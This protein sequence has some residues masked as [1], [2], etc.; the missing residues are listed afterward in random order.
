[1]REILIAEALGSTMRVRT[2]TVAGTQVASFNAF[3]T[4]ASAPS[5]A[6][7]DTDGDGDDE[8]I[9]ARSIGGQ[10]QVRI[11]TSS[12]ILLHAFFA[13]TAT[14]RGGVYVAAGDTDGDGDAE[15]IVG[16]GRGA[17][18]RVRVFTVQG[19][20]IRSFSAYETTYR[21]GVT[22]GAGDLDGDGTIEIVTGPAGARVP[23]VRV[24]STLGVLQR[25]MQ[26]YA[27]TYRSGVQL[28][29]GDLTDDGKSEIV[30]G[31]AARN[32]A[33]VR[34]F[35]GTGKLLN[36]FF[37]EGKSLRN[38]VR[39]LAYRQYVAP[40]P[41]YTV[42]FFGDQGMTEDAKALLRLIKDQGADAIVHLGDFDYADN[43]T[44]WEAQ[45]TGILGTTFPYLG[46]VGN[47]DVPVWS[48]YQTVLANQLSRTPSMRCVGDVG[49][50]ATCT[51][52][53]VTVILSGVG[54]LGTEHETYLAQQVAAA[55]GPWV[56][57]AWHKNQRLMQVGGKSDEVGWEAYDSCRGQGAIVATGHEHSYSR[58]HLL[59]NFATQE[60]ASTASELRLAPGKTFAFVS[61]LGGYSVR[62]QNASLAANPWW[63]SVYTSTQNAS[64]GA[65][66][67]TFAKNG[68]QRKASCTFRDIAGNTPDSF[69]LVSER[70]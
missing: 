23:D 49:E 70:W 16:S 59:S 53:G 50:Q 9:V 60:I 28:S 48:G 38:G 44:Q 34:I 2:V 42:A 15:V 10:P 64:A 25:S 40:Y 5:L 29:V 65:L 46:L 7:G 26:A 57:C 68:V 18:P 6:A 37:T 62:S 41:N 8:I 43:P 20:L 69:T 24:F 47:H 67:C 30:V 51:F 13:T 39:V 55:R 52:G 22:V 14:F 63:A 66:F 31:T 21:Q 56:I 32:G 35:R 61:G 1:M 12:G 17:L 45:Y 4:G 27:A 11:Y 3:T 54:T 19:T 36:A 33:Q 58:T